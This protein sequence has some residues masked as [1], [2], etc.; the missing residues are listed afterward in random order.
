MQTAVSKDL[1]EENKQQENESNS[2]HEE[3]AKAEEQGD[4][5]EQTVGHFKCTFFSFT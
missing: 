3:E 1:Q 4:V 5:E 2:V